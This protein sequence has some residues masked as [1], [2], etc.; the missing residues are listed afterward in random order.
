MP[1]VAR[2]KRLRAKEDSDQH[3]CTLNSFYLCLVFDLEVTFPGQVPRSS[4]FET[5]LSLANI[6]VKKNNYLLYLSKE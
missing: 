1:F 6:T 3:S 4:S 5:H 2:S